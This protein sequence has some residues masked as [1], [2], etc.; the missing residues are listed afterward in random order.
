MRRSVAA[1]TSAA[2]W[3]R[4]SPIALIIWSTTAAYCAWRSPICVISA[5]RCSLS[6]LMAPRSAA[7]FCSC[8]SDC[9]ALC[10]SPSFSDSAYCTTRVRASST[11]VAR[12]A[13]SRARWLLSSTR[14][15]CRSTTPVAAERD[16]RKNAEQRKDDGKAA[17]DARTDRKAIKTQVES[18]YAPRNC[19][20]AK[21]KAPSGRRPK[22]ARRGYFA[23]RSL[24]IT[25]APKRFSNSGMA[26]AMAAA[27]FA[28]SISVVTSMPACASAATPLACASA[29]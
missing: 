25:S 22:G 12:P 4:R 19:S 24:P 26:P 9:C 15:D 29:A 18:R 8:V 14:A 2:V 5:R 27:N 7:D 20:S 21:G 16:H 13:I 3:A 11:R 23:L 6:V 17:E 28:L 1:L 10:R